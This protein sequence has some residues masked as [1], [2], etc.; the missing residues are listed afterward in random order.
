MKASW[1]K[2]PWIANVHT[3]G[4]IALARFVLK[5]PRAMSV[6][7][8]VTGTGQGGEFL[9]LSHFRIS[10]TRYVPERGCLVSCACVGWGERGNKQISL[11]GRA[12]GRLV[13]MTGSH[14]GVGKR[15]YQAAWNY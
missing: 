1:A 15:S 10:T 2:C 8:S 13:V 9:R 12:R 4:Y 3:S 6:H 7:P 11:W 14:F 5:L